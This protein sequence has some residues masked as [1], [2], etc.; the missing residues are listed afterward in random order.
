MWINLSFVQRKT[1]HKLNN[2]TLSLLTLITLNFL[3]YD[4]LWK[5]TGARLF[6]T[7][8]GYYFNIL[9]K[10]VQWNLILNVARFKAGTFYLLSFQNWLF[11]VSGWDAFILFQMLLLNDSTSNILCLS[12]CVCMFFFQKS[13]SF[14]PY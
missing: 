3:S 4:Y 14:S 13:S 8:L 10:K 5:A 6:I 1:F 11:Q 12:N 9:W 7:F 2:I